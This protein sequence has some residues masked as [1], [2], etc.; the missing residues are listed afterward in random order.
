MWTLV[1]YKPNS[2]EYSMGCRVGSYQSELITSTHAT[3]EQLIKAWEAICIRNQ[4]RQHDEENFDIQIYENGHLVWDQINDYGF[5]RNTEEKPDF[6][7]AAD[8]L[9]ERGFHPDVIN[10]L[11][12]TLSREECYQ[13]CEQLQTEHPRRNGP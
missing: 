1:A 7:I 6:A 5:V 2:T 10:R 8:W 3:K 13:I 4:A 11:R 9:E 12:N